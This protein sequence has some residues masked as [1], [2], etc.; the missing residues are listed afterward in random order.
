MSH[1][2]PRHVDAETLVLIS[3][4]EIV[5]VTPKADG[6]NVRL[7]V[8][9][10]PLSG[11]QV[12]DL[13]YLFPSPW[14]RPPSRFQQKHPQW[15]KSFSPGWEVEEVRQY[16]SQEFPVKGEPHLRL[17]PMALLPLRDGGKSDFLQLI[18]DPPTTPYPNDGWILDHVTGLW[19]AKPPHEMTVDLYWNGTVWQHNQGG[20]YDFAPPSD[21]HTRQI[22]RLQWDEKA[23]IWTPRDPR[24]EKVIP[25]PSWLVNQLTQFHSQPWEP[26]DVLE[27]SRQPYYQQPTQHQES[28][29]FRE[30]GKRWFATPLQKQKGRWL[31]LGCGFSGIRRYV[32]PGIKY[33]GVDLD[34]RCIATAKLRSIS[35]H[36]FMV[37]DLNNF[38]HR[39]KVD[40][41]FIPVNFNHKYDAIILRHTLQ[42]A[43]DPIALLEY[44]RTR[45][46]PTGKI[47]VEGIDLDRLER[48]H[49]PESSPW[50]YR[51]LSPATVE[52]T[53]P[54]LPSPHLEGTIRGSELP[55]WLIPQP[56]PSPPPLG[57]FETLV[58]VTRW[59]E[60]G[61]I[62]TKEEEGE[63]E[64]T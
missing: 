31:D 37:G 39:W 54:W 8:Q 28:S 56:D 2:P 5:G 48:L 22:H 3:C 52:F 10:C 21:T 6:V 55:E 53:Y 15:L 60:G 58:S 45:L 17:K 50:N 11:E 46:T 23:Q 1:R 19:K 7:T 16:L 38:A 63:E 26:L 29:R 47:F 64:Y 33:T 34:P 36:Q 43:H 62:K 12:E 40:D 20:S 61:G 14:I 4:S 49:L 25:N 42:Y 27:Y 30:W 24:P 35:G 9:G 57:G 13:T 18:N 44:L 51:L 41:M 32:P 59:W